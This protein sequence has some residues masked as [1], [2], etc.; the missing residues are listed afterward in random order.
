MNKKCTLCKIEKDLSLFSGNSHRCKECNRIKMQKYREAHREIDKE[1]YHNNREKI[2]QRKKEYNFKNKEKIKIREQNRN[3]LFKE[4]KILIK[5]K[6][7]AKKLGLEFNLTIDDIVIP[8]FCPIL[9]IPLNR[10]SPTQ[11]YN[12]ASIDRIDNTKGYVKGNVC[13]ISKK[14]NMI[15]SIGTIEEHQKIIDYMKS[16]TVLP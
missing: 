7:R 14:A 8:E 3:I 11:S 13:V 5:I 15:K 16:Y 10:N 6:S 2:I 1:Y 9:G 12:S 4:H